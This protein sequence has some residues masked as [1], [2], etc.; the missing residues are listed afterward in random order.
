MVTMISDTCGYVL[1][2]LLLLLVPYIESGKF[3]PIFFIS[4]FHSWLFVPGE[5]RQAK[6]LIVYR[7][8]RCTIGQCTFLCCPSFGSCNVFLAR[9]HMHTYKL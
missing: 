6:S 8:D 1:F 9:C 7:R 5:S 2:L 3:V 4:A